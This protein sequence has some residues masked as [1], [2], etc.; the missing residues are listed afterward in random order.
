MR[1]RAAR[2]A[3][4][5]AV[6]C[7]AVAA[8]LAAI[9]GGGLGTKLVYAFAIGIACTVYTSLAR[10]AAAGASDL[11]R[12]RRGLPAAEAGFGAGWTG[13]LPALLAA[14]LAGPPTGLAIAD[15]LTGHASPSLL[16]MRWASTRLTIALAV[17]GTVA[18]IVVLSLQERLAAARLAAEAAERQAAQSRLRLLQSQLEPHMLFN[19][20]ANLRVLIGLD[21]AAAQSMLDRLIAFLRATLGA[22]QAPQHALAREFAWLDDYLA[23]MRVRMGERLHYEL[24][25]PP[26]LAAL[27]VPPLLLQPLVENAV[28]HGLEPQLAP[29]RVSVCAARAGD[30]LVLTVRDSGVGFAPGVPGV[31]RASAAGG[32]GGFGLAQVRERLST[33]YGPDAGL[34]LEPAA[35]GG[36]LATLHLPLARSVR[37]SA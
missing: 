9:D 23:L 26:E 6:L 33:I 22:S 1:R 31:P 17:I 3:L 12:R 36:T 2:T 29:G 15:R 10:L 24:D 14:M 7:L 28:R 19:T 11:W 25:L 18:S 21:A 32:G 34:S 35:G 20:L 4:F 5:V 27:P 13:V 30:A 37:G 16:E 8:L